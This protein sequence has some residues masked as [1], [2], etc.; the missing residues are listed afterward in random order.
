MAQGD[1]QYATMTLNP[2]VVGVGM[3]DRAEKAETIWSGQYSL[4]APN[5]ASKNNQGDMAIL[6]SNMD[7]VDHLIKFGMGDTPYD[8]YLEK[9]A[10]GY[11]WE[12]N[13]DA[14]GSRNALI[15]SGMHK[16]LNFDLVE[17]RVYDSFDLVG[18][19]QKKTYALRTVWLLSGSYDVFMNNGGRN[20]IGIPEPTTF[21]SLAAAGAIG[22]VCRRHRRKG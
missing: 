13:S 20:D 2:N 5:T 6:A 21:G 7:N 15:K 8:I 18:S 3:N 19:E 1:N 4:T 17:T 9:N 14:E 10:A 16:M 22:M 12:D 11:T